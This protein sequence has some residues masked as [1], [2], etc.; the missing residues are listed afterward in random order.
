[1]RNDIV[2]EP[3]S[4]EERELLDKMASVRQYGLEEAELS[5]QELSVVFSQF[6]IGCHLAD[7]S[8]VSQSSLECPECK[9]PITGVD[10]P[11]IGQEPTGVPC[12]CELEY[13][14]VPQELF[15]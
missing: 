12:G 6:A 11:G 10:V 8:G 7:Q 15:D 3:Q 4:E 14:Q 2:L 1:M 5:P 13:D 9:E